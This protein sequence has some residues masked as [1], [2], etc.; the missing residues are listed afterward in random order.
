MAQAA[1]DADKVERRVGNRLG[2]DEPTKS[3]A[4]W[5]FTFQPRV[6]GANQALVL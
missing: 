4:N 6:Q 1:S 2:A 3:V 5:H